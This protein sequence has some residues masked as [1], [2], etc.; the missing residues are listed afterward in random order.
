MK[1]RIIYEQGVKDDSLDAVRFASE[2]VYGPKSVGKEIN[3]GGGILPLNGKQI[4]VEK[5][6]DILQPYDDGFRNIVLY[7][8]DIY[9]GTL[10]FVY[11][12]SRHGTGNFAVSEY[13]LTPFQIAVTGIHE[14][15]HD[16][17]LVQQDE[18][19]YDHSEPL[20]GHCRNACIMRA[21]NNLTQ[22][23]IATEFAIPRIRQ[24]KSC[25]CPECT[26]HIEA[27]VGRKLGSMQA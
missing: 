21:V 26:R 12:A 16:L 18:L 1:T 6:L 13:R 9:A 2:Y 25:F 23:E 10:N 24:G 19:R 27:Q 5:I 15:G 4:N 11:G 7:R 14:F 20:A 8:S 3:M 22:I 17:G